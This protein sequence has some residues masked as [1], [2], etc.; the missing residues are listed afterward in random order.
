M[1]KKK[2]KP[3]DSP[4]EE[5]VLEAPESYIVRWAVEGKWAETKPMTTRIAKHAAQTLGPEFLIY[6]VRQAET[7]ESMIA[8]IDRDAL[9][10]KSDD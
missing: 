2:P 1:T 3:K 8:L 10:A 6:A 7:G 9:L 5:W 4:R